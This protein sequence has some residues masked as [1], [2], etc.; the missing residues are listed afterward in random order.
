MA[1]LNK[2]INI[3]VD[4]GNG[5]VTVD[6][7]TSS[8]KNLDKASQDLANTF[9]AK[10]KPAFDNTERSL[11]AQITILKNQRAEIAQTA[12]QYG[13]FSDKIR[14]LQAELS[15]LQGKTSSAAAGF[16]NM[17]NSSGLASQTLV[18]VGRTI[19]DANYGFT[20]V[21]NNLSQLGYYFITLTKEAGGFRNSMK[22]LGKQMLGAGGLII[23]F[24]LIIF[25]IE[26]YTLAQRGAKKATEDLT[27][28][29]AEAEASI[30]KLE[31]LNSILKDVTASANDQTNALRALV[32]DGYDKAIGGT[33]DYI[34]AKKELLKY[35]VLEKISSEDLTKSIQEELV[36]KRALAKDQEDTNADLASAKGYS[37]STGTSTQK[38]DTE[39]IKAGIKSGFV[40]RES[41]YQKQLNIVAT[42]RAKDAEALAN[43]FQEIT[44]NLEANPFLCLLFGDCKK[45]KGGDSRLKDFKTDL[46]DT[47]KIEEKFRQESLKSELLTEEEKIVRKRDFSVEEIKLAYEVYLEKEKI[48][49]QEYLSSK[50]TDEQKAQAVSRSL[51]A[52]KKAFQSLNDVITQINNVAASDATLLLRSR[53]E[54][55]RADLEA[56]QAFMLAANA[57]MASEK[58]NTLAASNR[59]AIDAIDLENEANIVAHKEKLRLLGV[60]KNARIANGLDTDKVDAQISLEVGKRKTQE[61]QSF[62]KSEAAKLAIANQVGNAI[63]AIAGEG[64]AVGKAVAVAMATMNTYEAVTAALGAKPYGPWNI[65]QAA[66]VAAMGFVQVRNILKTEIPSPKGGGGS[67]GSAGVTITPPDF[68]IVGQSASN[69][70]ASAV[71][72]Q[73]SQPVK[74][75]VVSKDVSTAQEMDRNIVATASLG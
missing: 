74:A 18:E 47:A 37:I 32:K 14:V 39:E 66:A 46:F 67:G 65:A 29:L 60:E 35:N 4:F 2:I 38:V 33:E 34:A 73:F 40:I 20:A 45:Q 9:I 19:S 25:L 13:Q 17:R 15:H 56:T 75:Y 52:Q 53:A 57:L 21:A 16:T 41:E 26:K 61:T 12:I 63:I 71:Q 31:S 1:E 51:E 6:G 3:R 50:A 44:D 30:T 36:I 72:G 70:L 64:S 49:L 22:D 8:I 55:F 24:Q 27:K 23:A 28:A 62:R 69:Q 10:V 54:I 7:L 48:R 68:N 11:L 42:K 58:I 59:S 43:M 5:K